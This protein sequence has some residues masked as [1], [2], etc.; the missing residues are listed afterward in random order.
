MLAVAWLG[1]CSVSSLDD[2]SLASS[3]LSSADGAKPAEVAA[4]RVASAAK[5]K[6]QAD[7]DPITTGSVGSAALPADAKDAARL[8]KVVEKAT[9]VADP[10][11]SAYKIGPLDV[12][13][14]SVFKVPELS[15]SLQ[16]SSVGTINVPLIGETRAAGR[17][18][19]EIEKD[20]TEQWGAKYLQ[21][22]QVTVFVK[23]YNSQRI[24]V[25]GAVNKPGV[26]PIQGRMTLLQA[27]A[28]AQGLS[29]ISESE[30]LVFRTEK[31]KRA[32]ARFDVSEIRTG[33]APDPALRAGDVVVAGRS[34][35]KEAFNNFAKV[36]P[37]ARAFVFF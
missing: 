6:A 31:G 19:R 10:N 9:A 29:E 4:P 3:S 14:I 13:E 34:F 21:S 37:I 2:A 5:E 12:L 1:G 28:T 33:D 8:K 24:T 16:V 30:V 18:A 32:A 15:K 25:E 17:T 26:Y 7:G 20:L 22:P 23:E 36:V 35:A 11:S 27:I